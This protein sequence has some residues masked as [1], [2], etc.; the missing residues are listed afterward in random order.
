MSMRRLLLIVI[1][2]I[3]GIAAAQTTT[4][5]QQGGIGLSCNAI[6]AATAINPGLAGGCTSL[7]LVTSGSTL[8]GN[9]TWQTI[10][11]GGPGSVS[12]TLVGSLDNVTWTTLD[13]NVS[14]AGSSR[15]LS[16]ASAYRFLGCVPGTFSGGASP[17]LTCQIS[18]TSTAGGG[19]GLPAGLTFAAPT[20]TVS[21]AG[22]GNGAL[23]L[24]GNTSG[25]ATLT[26]PAVAG[27]L[28]NPITISNNITVG[29]GAAATPGVAF[30]G[31]V[32]T[33]IWWDNAN[34]T[35]AFSQGATEKMALFSS[36]L[37]LSG[38]VGLQWTIGNNNPNL[39]ANVGLAPITVAASNTIGVGN[40]TIG[41][42]SG[43]VRS[44]N[45]CALS[46]DTTLTVNTA[47]TICSFTLPAVTKVWI[48]QCQLPWVISA[49]TGTNTISIGVNASQTPAGTTNLSGIIYTATAGTSINAVAVL[50]A[51]GAVNVLTS[52]TITPGATVFP[53]S[54]YGTLNASATA[55]TFA[56]TMT[57]AGTTAT[58]LSKAGAYCR[59][60]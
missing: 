51:S 33:G 1:L 15:V 47:I 45:S 46:S 41:T 21:T 6:T 7:A 36:L 10:T 23:A 12:V 57:A 5:L 54:L 11:T 27:T 59:L 30:T 18:V 16:N 8:P 40:G 35:L 31:S 52:G 49:G 24:S 48:I 26:A 32:G 2:L 14:T 34:S 43:F 22:S 44:A 29:N 58:A 56:V 53:A 42:E 38:N 20:L 13:T 17:T 19:G 60:E 25:T 37:A 39:A 4:L 9:Y 50:S 28:T 3:T 55:G